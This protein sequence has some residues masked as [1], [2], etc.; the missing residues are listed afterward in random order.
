MDNTELHYVTYDTDEMWAEMMRAYVDAGG[1]VLY[2]GDEKEMLLRAQLN[3]AALLLAGIDNGLRMATLRYAQGEYLDIYGEGRSC[4]RMEATY[5]TGTVKIT[6]VANGVAKTIPAGTALTADGKMTYLLTEDV[7]QTGNARTVTAGII[8]QTAGAAGNTLSG[9]TQMQ[10]V[11]TEG[12]VSNVVCAEGASGGSDAE[13]N[14]AY[15]ER[16]RRHGLTT[17]TTGT[18]DAYEQ[19]ALEA[20]GDIVDAKAV[21]TGDESVTVYI[22]AAEGADGEAAETAAKAAL[23]AKDK[24]PLTVDIDCAEAEDIPYAL[25]VVY[26]TEETASSNLTAQIE[27]AAEEY[28]EWQDF[29]IGRA[30]N[31]DRLVA[32]LYRAG[33][34]GVRFAE[35]SHFNGGEVEYTTI[36]E[37]QRCKGTITLYRAEA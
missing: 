5:A 16:I 13:E 20:T 7:V 23:T 29:K 24:R 27:A 11:N 25:N 15:R 34:M 3:I 37:D 22:L 36:D 9:G 21:K 26:T 2:G 32:Y 10:F 28:Q 4:Y 8:C 31:P 14:E 12:G 6:F 33:A 35:L 17:T 30:F 19:T 1:D 18:G